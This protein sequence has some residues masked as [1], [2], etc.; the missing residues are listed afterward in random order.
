MEYASAVGNNSILPSCW[1]CCRRSSNLILVSC[2]CFST[3]K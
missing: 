1:Y 2:E 3:Q